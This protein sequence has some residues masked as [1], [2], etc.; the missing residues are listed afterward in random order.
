MDILQTSLLLIQSNRK[1]LEIA[2]STRFSNFF[3]C[4]MAIDFEALIQARW[5]RNPYRASYDWN[6]GSWRKSL[7]TPVQWRG[8]R[9][10]FT[11][12]IV[13][14]LLKI[15]IFFTLILS[16]SFAALLKDQFF[17]VRAEIPQIPS[18]YLTL[19]VKKQKW[20]VK[21]AKFLFIWVSC[22]LR[23][24]LKTVKLFL[25]TSLQNRYYSLAYNMYVRSLSQ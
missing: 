15:Y 7:F 9:S 22:T 5:E 21:P 25:L 10:F 12:M 20:S 6:F 2:P 11:N 13:I 24:L 17:W 8:K 4:K 1:S 19:S 14:V 23:Y 3:K 16:Y 18:K